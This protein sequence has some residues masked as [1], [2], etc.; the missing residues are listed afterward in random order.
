MT[1][2]PSILL[3]TGTDDQARAR[4]ARE[5]RGDW[6]QAFGTVLEKHGYL[7]FEEAGPA[8]LADP[9]TWARPGVV[10]VA[11]MP[12]EAWTD[13]VVDRVAAGPAQVLLEH[14]PARLLQEH[15]RI[16]ASVPADAEGV[17][18]AATPELAAAV[19]RRAPLT[20]TRLAAPDRVAVALD[21]ARH[22]AQL[23]VPVSAEQ[24][25]AW[26]RPGWDA[27]RWTVAAD[28]EVLAHWT[29]AAGERSPAVVRRDAVTACSFSLLAFLAQQA[30]VPPLPAGEHLV[31]PDASA[32]EALLLALLDDLHR[33]AGVRRARV[34]AWPEGATWALGVRHDVDRA[35]SATGLQRVLD[36]HA[37]QGTAATWY[38]RAA[39]LRKQDEAPGEPGRPVD[40]R[41]LCRR[42]ALAPGQEV[43][44]HTERLWETAAAE[45]AEV[46]RAAARPV[47]GTSAHGDPSCFRWQGA[48]NVL[49]AERQGLAY[50]EFLSHRHRHPH[51]FAALS[52]DGTIALAEVVCLPRH[53]SLDRSTSEGDVTSDSVAEAAAQ[54]AHAGGYLQILNHPDIHV[55]PLFSALAALP[56][57]G[58][59]DWTAGEVADWWR[60]T[61]VRAELTVRP[62]PDGTVGVR[63]ERGVRGAVLDVLDP[64]GTSRRFALHIEPRQSVVVGDA[65]PGAAAG[66]TWAADVAPAFA[67]AVRA[68]YVAQGID[69]ASPAAVSTI[70]TN[71]ELVPGR[72]DGLRRYL[73]ALGGI[74]SLAGR[75][76]LD[77]GAGFGA[78]AACLSLGEDEPRVTAID[79]REDFTT[80]A[81]AVAARAGL[82]RV[83]YAGGDMRT[84]AGFD[85]GAFDVVVANNALLYLAGPGAME[86]ALGS[87]ARVTAP[88]G[89]IVVFQANR[90]QVR[91]PFS[92]D[93]LVH[94]LPR[95]L[96]DAAAR[97]V[98]WEHNQHRVRL[99]SA[100]RLARML[101]AAGFADPRVGLIRGRTVASGPRARLGRYYAVVARRP[102]R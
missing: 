88:G 85:D 31:W 56:A 94:L 91:E 67:D 20:G 61:H 13:A 81:E 44:H 66:P 54:H 29:D 36:G 65:V 49:W 100:G 8:A 27:E 41:V 25:D 97:T 5:G 47:A 57:D 12:D 1:V 2:R 64:D 10:L 77:A 7:A 102:A 82:D 40:G 53:V 16:S 89:R 101:G 45:Q 15:L 6:A 21:P 90:W 75:R 98:G 72:V 11:R 9:A 73:S 39:H 14:P 3:V 34:L 30:T 38:W 93:P 95:P 63:S 46:E 24:A 58:R 37:A 33:R 76:V 74:D 92:R 4:Y 48:P 26:S 50:T 51:R 69:P 17:V 87:L 84:L 22:W 55:D 79:V 35:P 19:A 52:A 62:R 23:D 99:V 43:A 86:E 83:A 78:F 32:L 68:Y 80:A 70:A 59:L 71:T 28:A 18:T 96:A 60:R 42:V